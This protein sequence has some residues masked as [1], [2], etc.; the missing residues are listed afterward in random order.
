M[1]FEQKHYDYNDFTGKKNEAPVETI[2]VET[3]AITLP[4]VVDAFERFL[5]ACGFYFNGKL[6]IVEDEDDGSI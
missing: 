5:K 2:V 6:D 4:E 3:E 1:K